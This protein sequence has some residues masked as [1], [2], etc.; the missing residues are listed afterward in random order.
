MD[1]RPNEGINGLTALS[2]RYGDQLAQGIQQA[3]ADIEGA[4]MRVTT[5]KQLQGLSGTL[6]QLDPRTKDYTQQ[7]IAIAPQ[8]PLALQDPRGQALI[9]MGAKE[10]VAWNQ[11][12]T[13]LQNQNSM[14]N[15]QINL[16]GLRLGNRETLE[17]IRHTNRLGEINTG[18]GAPI[19]S[20]GL[21]QAGV[22]AETPLGEPPNLDNLRADD[23]PNGQPQ[24]G[25]NG[26]GVLPP[27]PGNAPV[28]NTIN[29]DDVVSKAQAS[30]AAA[31]RAQI[32]SGGKP[33]YTTKNSA[34]FINSRIAEANKAAAKVDSP[35]EGLIDIPGQPGFQRN[36]TGSIIWDMRGSEPKQIGRKT[37]TAE[38]LALA[39]TEKLAKDSEQTY[40]K[41]VEIVSKLKKEQVDDATL[42]YH[43]DR[44]KKFEG[45]RDALRQRWQA[46]VGA[47][48]A[49]P[50]AKA[51]PV[52]APAKA[53]TRTLMFDPK[54]GS[55]VPK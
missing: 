15:R 50:D 5:Q 24:A 16:E 19:V 41:E 51:A 33:I 36:K 45:E 27:L 30:M 22:P 18:L 2:M 39:K 44:V 53:P 34:Q 29:M 6:S 43:L 12:Q 14:L 9:T 11:A 32:A 23:V 3:G 10:H 20:P 26:A 17:G 31:N 46:L 54:T 13:A 4:L 28:S 21:P 49:H 48:A 8:Y 38:D 7:L 1:I 35:M 37:T 40:N 47:D 52:A 25:V 55:F 42:K